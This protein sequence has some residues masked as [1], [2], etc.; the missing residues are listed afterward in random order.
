MTT[1][2]TRSILAGALAASLLLATPLAASAATPALVAAAAYEGGEIPS[3]RAELTFTGSVVPNAPVYSEPAS[4]SK[5]MTHVL[6]KVRALGEAE[7]RVTVSAPFTAHNEQWVAILVPET[8]YGTDTAQSTLAA[9]GVAYIRAGTVT[10]HETEAVA[11]HIPGTKADLVT[12]IELTHPTGLY[13][14]PVESYENDLKKSTKQ[15][16]DLLKSSAIFENFGKSWV[17]VEAEGLIPGGI[18]YILADKRFSIVAPVKEASPTAAPAAGE[19]QAGPAAA[20]ASTAQPGP[21]ASAA[22]AVR[23]VEPEAESDTFGKILGH[24][25]ATIFAALVMAYTIFILKRRPVE[26]QKG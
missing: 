1:G 12:T 7:D 19:V 3:T 26:A 5:T 4:S 9:P 11:Q 22:P 25:A 23:L 20:S 15:Q 13:K 14:Q 18:A 16:G 21:T 8:A 17:A 10:L 6:P 24:V 2:T